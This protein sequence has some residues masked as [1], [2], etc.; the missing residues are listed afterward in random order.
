MVDGSAAEGDIFWA[1]VREGETRGSEQYKGRPWLI[2][3]RSSLHAELPMVVAVPLSSRV[4][5]ANRRFRIVIPEPH[6]GGLLD[7]GLPPAA[8]VLLREAVWEDLPVSTGRV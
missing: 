4:E 5:K 2:V 3:S 6:E 7:Q 8:A 1:E